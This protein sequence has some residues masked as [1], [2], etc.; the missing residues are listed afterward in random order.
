[1]DDEDENKIAEIEAIMYDAFI[2]RFYELELEKG[3]FMTSEG[4]I[5]IERDMFSMLYSEGCP[6]WER[7]HI[8]GHDAEKSGA[9][10]RVVTCCRE[11]VRNRGMTWAGVLML[12]SG[13]VVP[14]CQASNE[15]AA[16]QLL[17]ST[18]RAMKSRDL[19][20]LEE[21]LGEK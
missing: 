14:R 2:S 17:L 18:L 21:E 15:G 19:A 5:T 7:D 3:C 13:R 1:M 16:L 4:Y 11:L 6:N 12:V 9:V 20:A 8:G 10:A